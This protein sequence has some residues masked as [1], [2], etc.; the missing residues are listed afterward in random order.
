MIPESYRIVKTC[1]NC[2]K[3]FRWSDYD[4]PYD[5]YCNRNNDRP[6]CGSTAMGEEFR[7]WDPEKNDY[8]LRYKDWKSDEWTIWSEKNRVSVFGCCDEHVLGDSDE[9]QGTKWE[10]E[11]LDV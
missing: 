7:G 3:C 11:R 1:A 2:L 9:F 5:Y 10:L 8:V 6:P 4:D